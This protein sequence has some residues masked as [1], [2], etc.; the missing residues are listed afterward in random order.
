MAKKTIFG[1]GLPPL[2]FQIDYGYH[3]PLGWPGNL[4]EA[5]LNRKYSFLPPNGNTEQQQN[6]NRYKKLEREIDINVLITIIRC[7]GGSIS[8]GP[9]SAVDIRL[10]IYLWIFSIDRLKG[11]FR[12]RLADSW[13]GT[14]YLDCDPKKYICENNKIESRRSERFEGIGLKGKKKRLFYKADYE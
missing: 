4:G 9:S 3:A 11:S 6:L 1:L 8:E 14:R 12:F 5:P 13:D 2:I 7:I 10:F